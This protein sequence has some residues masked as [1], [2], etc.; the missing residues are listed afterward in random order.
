MSALGNMILTGTSLAPVLFVYAL[1][2]FADSKW[3]EGALLAVIGLGMFV[4]SC[5]FLKH[6]QK[7]LERLTV[8]F[9]TAEVADRETVGVMVLYMLPLLRTSFSG[10]ELVILI[11]AVAIFLAL[12]ITGYSYHF[13][14]LLALMGWKFYKVTTSGGVGYLLVT[15]KDLKNVTSEFSVGQL[16]SHTVIDVGDQQSRR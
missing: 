1:L 13:N 6:V 5:A 16:T 4:S 14:P 12:S 9:L 3:R 15:Q 7:H 2:A 8:S 10:L 11:P